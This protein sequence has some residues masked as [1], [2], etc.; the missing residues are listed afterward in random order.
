MDRKQ[1]LMLVYREANLFLEHHT[2]AGAKLTAV[3][4]DELEPELHQQLQEVLAGADSLED[5]VKHSLLRS[6]P[7]DLWYGESNWQ[8]VLVAVASACLLHDVKGVILKIVEGTLPRI[9]TAQLL[10]V[11]ETKKGKKR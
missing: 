4:V 9:S 7:P 11:V 3:E 6:P 8:H 5:V 10:D 2:P 1:W